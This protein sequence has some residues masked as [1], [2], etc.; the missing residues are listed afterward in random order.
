M[1]ICFTRRSRRVF[2]ALPP[3]G[4]F[5]IPT[6]GVLAVGLVLGGIAP[7][8]R[9]D[10]EVDARIKDPI[11][12]VWANMPTSAQNAGDTIHLVGATNEA[13]ASHALRTARAVIAEADI[14]AGAWRSFKITIDLV[15]DVL[16]LGGFGK[17]ADL[18]ELLMNALDAESPEDFLKNMGQTA[19]KKLTAMGAEALG[20]DAEQDETLD[21][22]VNKLGDDAAKLALEKGAAILY[23]AALAGE[24]G[25][26]YDAVV[27]HAAC[28]DVTITCWI[29]RARGGGAELRMSINGGCACRIPA[30]DPVRLGAF[31]VYAVAPLRASVA[32]NG[33]EATVEFDL[34]G[35]AQY[36]IDADCKCED[37]RP[38]EPAP[39]DAGGEEAFNPTPEFTEADRACVTRCLGERLMSEDLAAR[40]GLKRDA[41]AAARPLADAARAE[42]SRARAELDSLVA[43][44][45]QAERVLETPITGSPTDAQIRELTRARAKAAD[46]NNG[47]LERVRREEDALRRR[48][49][50]A[51]ST[52][53]RAL[54]EAEVLDTR[55]RD[56]R[57]R[58]EACL[59]AC[60]REQCAEGRAFGTGGRSF[61]RTDLEAEVQADLRAMK[62]RMEAEGFDCGD[63]EG[64]AEPVPPA[65]PVSGDAARERLAGYLDEVTAARVR[66]EAMYEYGAASYRSLEAAMDRHGV[67]EAKGHLS[68]WSGWLYLIWVNDAR[69]LYS[70]TQESLKESQR[71]LRGRAEVSADEMAYLARGMQAFRAADRHMEDLMAQITESW[72]LSGLESDKRRRGEPADAAKYDRIGEDAKAA[73]NSAEAAYPLF[74]PIGGSEPPAPVRDPPGPPADPSLEHVGIIA[75]NAAGEPD[76]DGPATPGGSIQVILKYRT[77]PEQ[78]A[79]TV[80]V[81]VRRTGGALHM[82]TVPVA[83]SEQAPAVLHSARIPLVAAAADDRN[84]GPT[85]VRAGDRILVD[86]NGV[87]GEITVS[88]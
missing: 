55:S 37:D 53:E 7:A 25:L 18:A 31:S 30:G 17:A 77:P 29:T 67:V 33:D 60:V 10:V 65:G 69:G 59:R 13:C 39:P 63:P 83:A 2:G 15:Q 58:Y 61:N 78:G 87:T 64:V 41:A 44:I 68:A 73:I 75:F 27:P 12:Q 23:D 81:R 22:F 36:W 85:R 62:R 4:L 57:V 38:A 32:R 43:A 48:H 14:R 88:D 11:N 5:R 46:R 3:R 51:R 56:H 21:Q 76:F 70:S 28:G 35:P 86:V 19:V 82:F 42:W 1:G 79:R 16:N 34:A 9:A 84:P 74:G 45:E 47:V 6:G 80:I 66:M 40:A 52:E 49:E 50:T 20:L 8:A 54:R 26:L 71:R 24:E 72:A